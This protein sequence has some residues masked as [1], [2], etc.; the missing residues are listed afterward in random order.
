MV[1][2]GH[3]PLPTRHFL[4][5]GLSKLIRRKKKGNF[6]ERETI[7]KCR[8]SVVLGIDKFKKKGTKRKM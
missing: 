6:Y 1:G 2:V 8:F 7:K 3:L 5:A 4:T